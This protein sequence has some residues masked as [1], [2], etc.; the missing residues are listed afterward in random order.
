MGVECALPGSEDIHALATT[1]LANK[2]T[3]M[4]SSTD[5]LLERHCIFDQRHDGSIDIFA[6]QIPSYC[7][8]SAQVRSVG[9]IVVA[10]IAVRTTRMERR[11]ASRKAE[12]AFSIRCQRSATWMA[13][14]SALEAASP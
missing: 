11:T 12:L 13:P 3:A 5:D 4:P 8:R 2:F 10:P 1:D 14:G 9:L 6:S 7:S